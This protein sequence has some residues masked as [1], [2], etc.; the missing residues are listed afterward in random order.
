GSM[1]FAGSVSVI[2]ITVKKYPPIL[3]VIPVCKVDPPELS[4]RATLGPT[5]ANV[6]T[7]SKGEIKRPRCTDSPMILAKEAVA[8]TMLT[9]TLRPQRN[10][11]ADF[12]AIG[13]AAVTLGTLRNTCATSRLP[14]N[15]ALVCG[16]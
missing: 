7:S 13:A 4:A 5:T 3:R 14:G 2:P 8:P 11:L 16:E 10:T 15:R 6:S 9:S 1:G 12:T